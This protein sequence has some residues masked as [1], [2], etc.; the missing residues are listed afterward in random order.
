[1]TSVPTLLY[2]RFD[3]H[4]TVN[5]ASLSPFLTHFPKNGLS[6]FNKLVSVYFY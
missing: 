1:M 6:D 5:T 4:K 2:A 3:Y